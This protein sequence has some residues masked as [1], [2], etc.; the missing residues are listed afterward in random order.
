MDVGVRL[1][2][3][4]HILG[5]VKSLDST[6]YANHFDSD[7]DFSSLGAEGLDIG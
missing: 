6:H 4:G 1:G 7:F 3:F 5:F 2:F